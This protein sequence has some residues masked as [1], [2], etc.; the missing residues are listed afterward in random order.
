MVI[1]GPSM[2]RRVFTAVNYH[3]GNLLRERYS[4]EELQ[5]AEL[6]PVSPKDRARQAQQ[7]KA[8]GA[9]ANTAKA[10]E[11]KHATAQLVSWSATLLDA[12]KENPPASIEE[13]DTILKQLA[14]AVSACENASQ[15]LHDFREKL[16]QPSASEPAQEAQ[17]SEAPAA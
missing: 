17:E 6:D 8:S 12:I 14:T 2:R 3:V 5:M 1:D 7:N 9:A 11:P 10:K 4:A 16:A 13:V 15:V